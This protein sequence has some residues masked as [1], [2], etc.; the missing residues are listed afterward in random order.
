MSQLS[1]EATRLLSKILG[2][3]GLLSQMP[4]FR[5]YEVN[6]KDPYKFCWTTQR[7]SNG[8]FYALIYRV[9]KDGTWVL[10]KKRVFGHRKT[11]KRYAKEW[12]DKRGSLNER[13]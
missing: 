4:N 12:C 6:R 1:V 7:S 3:A 9:R 11:A 5:Y 2:E 10:K 13:V 8:K